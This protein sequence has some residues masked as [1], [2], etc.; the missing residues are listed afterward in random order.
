MKGSGNITLSTP[1]RGNDI[2]A[3]W[4]NNCSSA[5]NGYYSVKGCLTNPNTA[6]TISADHFIDLARKVTNWT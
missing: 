5:C 1:T 4:Y 3:T 6:T 2:T